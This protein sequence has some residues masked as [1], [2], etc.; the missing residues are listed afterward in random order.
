[1][2]QSYLFFADDSLLFAT[3]D[4]RERERYTSLALRLQRDTLNTN[5]LV[6]KEILLVKSDLEKRKLNVEK[7]CLQYGEEEESMM[8]A[9][10]DCSLANAVWEQLN[11]KWSSDSNGFLNVAELVALGG[12]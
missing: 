8:H 6:M 7:S 12:M 2:S 4:S 1:M 5:Y 9:I 11:F 10:E 3:V